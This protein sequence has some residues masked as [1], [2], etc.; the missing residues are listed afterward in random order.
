MTRTQPGLNS[1]GPTISLA[2][3]SAFGWGCEA[4]LTQAWEVTEPRLF[5]ARIE[6]EGAPERPRPRFEERFAVR[7]YLAVPPELQTPLAS[8]Y[9]M[10]LALCLGLRTPDGRLACIA[11]QE[12]DPVLEPLS[13]TEVLLSGLGIDI[14]KVKLP[15]G[16]QA[17]QSNV[18]PAE[19]GALS[20]LDR[21]VI[22][23]ALCVDGRVERVPGRTAPD[24]PPSQLYHCVDN[25]HSAFPDV[26]AFTLSVLLDRGRSFDVNRNPLFACD[27]GLPESVCNTGVV[28]PNES[29]VAGAF[30]LARPKVPNRAGRELVAWPARDPSTPVSWTG[31]KADPALPQVAAGTDEHTVRVRFDSSD[32]EHY[33]YEI[34]SNGQSVLRR[35]REELMLD[36]ALTENGGE[37]SR[38]DSHLG[39]A[40]PDDAAEIS[41]SYVPPSQSQHA[42]KHI[43]TDGRLVRFYFT[44]RDQR[45]GV[46]FTMR[47]LCLIESTRT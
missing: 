37:L 30:V 21:L 15:E 44:V 26:S 5:G 29:R 40:D 23:G 18:T 45:G 13:D 39:A 22:F 41:F 27:P 20:D 8:R 47:E 43:P 14:S 42:D 36:H 32:R 25:A 19:R 17:V 6:V 3:L 34:S 12:L 7:Q 16:L 1:P 4:G 31:C 10:D 9:S 33:E 11:E 28:R 2:L 38:A 24:S 46:D 35:A